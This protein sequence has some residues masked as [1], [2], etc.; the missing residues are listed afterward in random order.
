MPAVPSPMTIA[1]AEPYLACEVHGRMV[2]RD[3]PEESVGEGEP[4][5]YWVCVG[6]DGEW[7]EG[8]CAGPVSYAARQSLLAGETYWPGVVVRD[9]EDRVTGLRP[10]T[11]P[12][13]V[14]VRELVNQI[15][16]AGPA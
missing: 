6:F 3:V 12:A 16:R 11:S 9:G 8:R 1:P 13:V 4:F 7:P 14:K 10:K 15:L 2:H 5:C